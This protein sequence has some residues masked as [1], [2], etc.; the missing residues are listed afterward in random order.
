MHELSLVM[1][2]IRIVEGEM[3]KHKAGLIED[4]ELEIGT[5][6]GVE[7]SAFDFA[8]GQAIKETPLENAQRKIKIIEGEGVC[9]D[10]E[11]SFPMNA[12]YDPCPYCG[13]HLVYIQKGKEFR[14]KSLT[15]S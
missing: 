9:Q 11:K 1:G 3:R 15:V 10:C 4:I 13:Q 5:L 14:V 8:W 6:S 2:V 12:F 7:M